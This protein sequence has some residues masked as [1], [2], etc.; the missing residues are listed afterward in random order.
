MDDSDLENMTPEQVAQLQKENCIF[1]KIVAGE[2]PS[3]K[4]YEDSEFIGILDIN[5]AADGHVLLLPKQHYQIMPQMPPELVGTL[6]IAC[7]AV[8]SKIISG[9]KCNGT[10]IF[11]ANGAVAGQ[12]APHFIV[13]VIPRN[14][15]DNISLNPPHTEIDDKSFESIRDSMLLH[16]GTKPRT[17]VSPQA[18][19]KVDQKKET[20]KEQETTE[21]K[22]RKEK[23]YKALG[24]NESEYIEEDAEDTEQNNLPDNEEEEED[25]DQNNTS[26]SEDND[27]EEEKPKKTPARK[28]TSPSNKIDYDKLG[29]LFG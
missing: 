8:S 16:L 4:V 2:I 19:S 11:I 27:D 1:C 20:K 5:P 23:E 18:S 6:G 12:R 3:K 7:S 24:D 26:G 29:R 25:S 9:F 21:E 17:K 28:T 15:G 14:E 10:S 13:H 22:T